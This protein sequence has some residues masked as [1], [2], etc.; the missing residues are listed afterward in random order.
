MNDRQRKAANDLVDLAIRLPG[1]VR[2]VDGIRALLITPAQ[3]EFIRRVCLEASAV[4]AA[5]DDPSIN[6]AAYVSVDGTVRLPPRILAHLGV[7]SGGGVMFDVGQ[8][9][10]IATIESD[11]HWIDRQERVPAEADRG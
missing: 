7:Q 6:R 9:P 4:L 2:P 11:G 5:E 3:I 10:G 8:E 1:V